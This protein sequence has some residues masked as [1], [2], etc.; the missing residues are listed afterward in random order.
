MYD[1]SNCDRKSQLSKIL[2]ESLNP[3]EIPPGSL[4]TL[5]SFRGEGRRVKFRG[6]FRPREFNM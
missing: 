3:R 6:T 5:L 4:G 2:T 1:G